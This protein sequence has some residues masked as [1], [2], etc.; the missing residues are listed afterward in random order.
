MGGKEKSFQELNISYTDDQK[1]ISYNVSLLFSVFATDISVKHLF[2]NKIEWHIKWNN[3]IKSYLSF[4]KIKHSTQSISSK[5][6][7]KQSP[8]FFPVIAHLSKKL[9][10]MWWM[11]MYEWGVG[12]SL[13]VCVFVLFQVSGVRHLMNT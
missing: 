13:C 7:S 12:M 1:N 6:A 11:Y 3:T 8:F 5:P 9:L 2:Q 4:S 10:W